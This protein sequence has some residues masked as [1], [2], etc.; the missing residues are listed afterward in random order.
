MSSYCS[1]LC[2]PHKEAQAGRADSQGSGAQW[3]S[4]QALEQPTSVAAALDYILVSKWLIIFKHI[5]VVQKGGF[6]DDISIYAQCA[7]VIFTRAVTLFSLSRLHRLFSIPLYYWLHR[8]AESRDSQLPRLLLASQTLAGEEPGV[9]M[10]R[11]SEIEIILCTQT[12]SCSPPSDSQPCHR[13]LMRSE[14]FLET[15]CLRC[16]MWFYFF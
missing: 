11:E 12:L 3:S 8:L 7:L 2:L 10:P 1:R 15:S 9:W 16:S 6:Y 13:I 4:T 14:S 5:L